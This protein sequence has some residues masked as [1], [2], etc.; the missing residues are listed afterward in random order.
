MK[1][2]NLQKILEEIRKGT[3]QLYIWKIEGEIWRNLRIGLDKE[4][5][6][7]DQ[8]DYYERNIFMR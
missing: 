6:T 2:Q 7:P 4:V 5:W 1:K 3:I 8:K